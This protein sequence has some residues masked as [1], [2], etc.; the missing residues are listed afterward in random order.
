MQKVLLLLLLVG[1][2]G[3]IQAQPTTIV[4]VRH[5]EKATDGKD[6]ELSEA[7]VKRSHQLAALLQ[8]TSIAEIYTTNYKRTKAT[9][10]PI[11]LQKNL[12]PKVYEPSKEPELLAILDKNKGKT[13]LMVGHSN[14]TPWVANT[15]TGSKLE[16]F[17]D[18]D[19]GN[20]LII[21]ITDLSK[22]GQPNNST[23]TW[24]SY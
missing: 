1:L 14:T 6:P 2:L 24:L 5:A 12:E 23:T 7:G 9:V 8:K 18:G 16:P 17:A 15:I 3:E 22:I 4:L 19:F 21:T 11:A 20:I 13:I 10:A